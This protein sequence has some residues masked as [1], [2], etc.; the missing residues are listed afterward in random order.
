M[1]FYPNVEASFQHNL[2]AAPLRWPHLKAF[3]HV[4]V[5]PEIVDFAFQAYETVDWDRC[6][7]DARPISDRTI[8]Y[9][10]GENRAGVMPIEVTYSKGWCQL[11]ALQKS[12]R[13]YCGKYQ[14]G[15][16]YDYV[17]AVDKFSFDAFLHFLSFVVA[18]AN[19]PRFVVYDSAISRQQR[20]KLSRQFGVS[21]LSVERIRWN[22]GEPV[23]SQIRSESPERCMPLHFRRGH[24]RRAEAHFV[25]ATQRPDALIEAD[26]SLW[27]QWIS[28]TW[29]G[30]PAFGF[31]ASVHAPM[32]GKFKDLFH[33]T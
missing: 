22:I 2:F 24:W 28:E 4:L 16:L 27:W 19:Q 12:E 13:L 8:F 15:G 18:L 31:K 6:L 20:R 29:V 7:V 5:D 17:E 33:G 21:D 11:W 3:Q 30:H 23:E 25:G 1:T 32:L 9:V 26:R 14:P 10:P